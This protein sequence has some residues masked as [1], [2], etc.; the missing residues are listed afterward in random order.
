[1]STIYENVFFLI[2]IRIMTL[3]FH[4]NDIV[5]TV[6]VIVYQHSSLDGK[7]GRGVN[8]GWVAMGNLGKNRH[9][10]S[11]LCS[12]GTPS[13]VEGVVNYCRSK[14]RRNDVRSNFE[15]NRKMK[16]KNARTDARV[17]ESGGARW[18]FSP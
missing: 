12:D 17:Y 11:Y 3:T 8:G 16:I 4:F 15:Q 2:R 9:R 18:F 1:M 13:L 14:K 7:L 6:L 5:H 10:F